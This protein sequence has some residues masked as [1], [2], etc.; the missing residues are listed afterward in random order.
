MRTPGRRPIALAGLL[1]VA[2]L[3]PRGL[4]KTGA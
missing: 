2:A 1:V 4:L 3:M